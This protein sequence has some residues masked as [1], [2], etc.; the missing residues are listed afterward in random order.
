VDDSIWA[1]GYWYDGSRHRT[2]VERWDGN[3]WNIVPSPSPYSSFNTLRAVLATADDDVSIGGDGRD[4]SGPASGILGSWDGAAWTFEPAMEGHGVYDITAGADGGLWAVGLSRIYA[5]VGSGWTVS[6]TVDAFLNGVE[7]AGDELWAVGWRRAG[8]I[9]VTYVARFAPDTD[10]DGIHDHADNCPLQPNPGQ[11]DSDGDG[12]GDACDGDPNTIVLVPADATRT[13]STGHTVIATVSDV[14][15]RPVPGVVVRFVV[16]GATST[17]G[18]CVTES[19]GMCE[20]AYDGPDLPGTDS[21][22]AHVDMDDDG[23]HDATEPAAEPS[24]VT[25][26]APQSTHGLVSGQAWVGGTPGGARIRLKIVSS[27]DGLTGM[28]EVSDL[29]AATNVTCETV[30]AFARDGT[31]IVAFGEALINGQSTSY[32]ID[33]QDGGGVPGSDAIRFQT[34]SG[35]LLEGSISGGNIHVH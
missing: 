24:T 4:V 29:Q 28:C 10:G 12:D 19:D 8:G 18:R 35:Y 14:L 25:W 27:T 21:I 2:L 30:T 34:T 31:T 11:S 1:A 3:S 7:L 5:S 23:H 20:F 13:V 32:R 15:A 26:T 9:P 17:G 16:S 33:A 22:A 6:D